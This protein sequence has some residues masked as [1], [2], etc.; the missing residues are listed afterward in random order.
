[1][2]CWIPVKND[3][4]VSRSFFGAVLQVVKERCE[5]A[6]NR[7]GRRSRVLVAFQR[8]LGVELGKLFLM[9]AL[10]VFQLR[11]HRRDLRRVVVPGLLERDALPDGVGLDRGEAVLEG[12]LL[13]DRVD[14]GLLSERTSLIECDAVD[15][16]LRVP[17][18]DLRRDRYLVKRIRA[19]PF[20]FGREA[21]F[22]T[23]VFANC[24]WIT[25]S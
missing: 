5:R 9:G 25:V 20:S 8:R 16:Y 7:L 10:Q 12:S 23:A 13:G 19:L 14:V 3:L 24:A 11:V 21:L 17:D 1:M 15:R 4:N 18:V 6:L 2:S 22:V